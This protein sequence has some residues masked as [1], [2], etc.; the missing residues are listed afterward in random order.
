L[1]NSEFSLSGISF[2]VTIAPGQS[3][4]FTLTFA[5]QSTGT[6]NGVLS[7]TSNATNSPTETLTGN[8][9]APSSHSA[10]L[11]WTD[12]SSGITGYNVYRGSVSGGPYSKINSALDA[13]TAYTDDSV[14]AG[15]T[16]Y[17]VTT[18]VDGSGGESGYSNEAQAVI[19]SP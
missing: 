19:P 6:A 2:P 18:A 1:N 13:N 11:T 4:P 12:G 5:P 7:F 14:L 17:Y 8:G 16:Y 15:Q 9:V 10:A 3:V